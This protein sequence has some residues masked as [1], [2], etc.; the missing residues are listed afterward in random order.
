MSL[1]DKLPTYKQAE[2]NL[3]HKSR[4]MASL[5]EFLTTARYS[6]HDPDETFVVPFHPPCFRVFAQALR[7]QLSREMIG[8]IDKA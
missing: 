1:M 3:P 6:E 4:L 2:P 8:I 5:F 7:Y